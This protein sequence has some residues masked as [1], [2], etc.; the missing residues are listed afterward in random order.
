MSTLPAQPAAGAAKKP[1]ARAPMPPLA[2]L[3]VDRD[4]LLVL[5]QR[6]TRALLWMG[7]AIVLLIVA[8]IALVVVR[9][10]PSYF[11]VT[12]SLRLIHLTP[13]DK[14]EVPPSAVADWAV[15]TTA[16]TFSFG[17]TNYRQTLI[18]VRDRYTQQ[19]YNEL[20]ASLAQTLSVVKS[21]HLDIVMTPV[22]APVIASTGVLDGRYAWLIQF[23]CLMSYE[24]AGIIT[25][26]HLVASVTV[27]QVPATRNPRQVVVAQIVLKQD[28]GQSSP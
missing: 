19:S 9:P 17:F 22:S 23:R 1:P 4:N 27:E 6:L 15:D 7:A 14:P 3:P 2:P 10:R 11:A 25:T 13:L 20:L 5:A 28:E 21:K 8:V 12:P 16:R 26:Q 18:G 24:P